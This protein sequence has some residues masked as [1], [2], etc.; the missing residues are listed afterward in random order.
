MKQLKM[1]P[2]KCLGCRSCELACALEND[3]VLATDRSRIHVIRFLE[4]RELGLP[5][6]QIFVCR[7]CR[8]APCLVICPESALHR[9]IGDELTICVVA[10][11]CTGCGLCVKACPFGAIRIEPESKKA[12]KCELCN[13]KPACVAMCPS[14]AIMFE[15]QESF[16]AKHTA[17]QMKGISILKKDKVFD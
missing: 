3:G 7:Q 14:G 2:D 10:E 9:G 6:N 8:D 5:S 15:S 11:S 13:G 12:V 17:L 4:S 1:N 16:F